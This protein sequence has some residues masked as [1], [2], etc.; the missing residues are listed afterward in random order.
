[1]YQVGAVSTLQQKRDKWE[2]RITTDKLAVK[3]GVF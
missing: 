2:N 1:M 3:I